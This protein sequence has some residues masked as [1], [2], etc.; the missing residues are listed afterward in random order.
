M[1]LATNIAETSLTIQGISVVV[2]AGFTRQLQFDP[3]TGLDRLVTVRVSAASAEQRTGRAG[4]LGPGTCYRLWTE[5]IQ[6]TLV[7]FSLPEIRTAD[8]TPLALELALWGVNEAGALRWLDA[9]PAASLAEGRR[10][11]TMLGALDRSGVITRHGKEMAR[12]PLH[13]RL[14]HMLLS[15]K[16]DGLVLRACDLAALLSERDILRSGP[17]P[18][19]TY[20]TDSDMVDRMEALD[21]WRTRRNTSFAAGEADPQACGTVDRTARHLERLLAVGGQ[22][23]DISSSEVSALVARAYPDRIARRRE[24][25]SE[26]Y[27][28]ANGRGGSLSPRSGVRGREFIIAVVME[29][30]ERGDGLIHTGC[31]LFPGADQAGVLLR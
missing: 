2:D 30:G 4:R 27:L 11:L 25:G 21:Q 19:N 22:R 16:A 24:P 3:A 1:V 29:G 23:G 10:L 13:P 7:P 28:L 26:R 9:P 5:H 20:I 31:G 17:L 15:S 14:A 6:D 12:L 18:G 8:L